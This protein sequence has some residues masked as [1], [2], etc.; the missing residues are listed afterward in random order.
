MSSLPPLAYKAIKPSLAA[1][2]DA[3]TP[4]AFFNYFSIAIYTT[5][6]LFLT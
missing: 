5:L 3:S 4:E 1:K 6:T 2:L